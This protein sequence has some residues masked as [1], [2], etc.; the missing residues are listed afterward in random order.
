LTPANIIGNKIIDFGL[1]F[2]SKRDE[3]M[4]DDLLASYYSLREHERALFKAYEKEF[5]DGKTIIE[6]MEKIRGRVRYANDKG[7]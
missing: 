6:R 3:D 4:A 7:C 1:S 5:K 2:M